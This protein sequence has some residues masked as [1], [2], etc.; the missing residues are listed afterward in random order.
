M[1]PALVKPV[2]NRVPVRL[3]NAGETTAKLVPGEYLAECVAVKGCYISQPIRQEEGSSLLEGESLTSLETKR[4]KRKHRTKVHRIRAQ[5]VDI[6]P[7]VRTIPEH[8][9]DLYARSAVH[10][11]KVQKQQLASLLREES[12]AFAKDG[13][14]TGRTTLVEHDIDTGHAYP[15]RQRVRHPPLAMRAIESECVEEMIKDDVIEP[16]NSP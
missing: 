4:L 2:D 7:L 14:G 5:G 8:L 13:E 16:S 11:T 1:L 6:D 9:R 10:L 12:N 3:I 15:I